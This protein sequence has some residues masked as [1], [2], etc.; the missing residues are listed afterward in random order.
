MDAVATAAATCR[1]PTQVTELAQLV[2]L[3]ARWE[4]MRQGCTP[5]RSTQSAPQALVKVQR[6]YDA[7][8]ETLVRYNKR[9]VPAHVPE[10]LLNTPLRLATW[11]LAMRNL[12]A[13]LE[14]DRQVHSPI[15]LVEKAY[16]AA[17]RISVRL[18]TDAISRSP[19]PGTVQAALDN[20]QILA[21]WCEQL[22]AAGIRTDAVL[23]IGVEPPARTDSK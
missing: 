2:E 13:Q 7:F 19:A 9:H 16:C 14:H 17:D 5:A 23:G 20:L 4:N 1:P 8:H 22:P 3:E 6:A 11:C 18:G 15:H 12:Y 21:N 10:L